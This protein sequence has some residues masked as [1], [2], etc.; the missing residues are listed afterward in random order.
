MKIRQDVFE[1][2]NWSTLKSSSGIKPQLV[3]C[4]GK[5]EILAQP[6][7]FT[8]LRAQFPDA[9][10]VSTSSSGEVCNKSFIEDSIVATALEFE[11]TNIIVASVNIKA[12][13]DSS[14]AGDALAAKLPLNNLRFVLLFSDGILVNGGD[15]IA[16]LSE[17]LKNKIPVA[18]GMAGDD[19]K[20]IE[21]VIGVNNDIMPGNIVAIGFYG[22]KLSLGFGNKGGWNRFGPSRC[23]TNS[24]KNV[25]YEL[26][27][28]NALDLYKNILGNLPINFRPRHF[29]FHWH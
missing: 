25:L 17:A 23:I 11:Q 27:G 12:Y 22:D 18:G 26:D 3:L 4:F 5:R 19:E 13:N 21:T 7:W 10:I 28:E 8:D 24:N 14:L 15:L 9:T 2:R 6:Y 29:T 1:D 20:F 16:S